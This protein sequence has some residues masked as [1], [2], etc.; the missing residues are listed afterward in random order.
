MLKKKQ[1]EQAPEPEKEAE[2]K[3]ESSEEE[4]PKLVTIVEEYSE[5]SKQEIESLPVP[6]TLQKKQTMS[7]ILYPKPKFKELPQ[8]IGYTLQSKPTQKLF[9]LLENT[10]EEPP[11]PE[12]QHK[13]MFDDV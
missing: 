11:C 10:K 12:Q 9:S 6:A 7:Q 3:V 1:E 8:P 2:A 13:S 5:E 4:K